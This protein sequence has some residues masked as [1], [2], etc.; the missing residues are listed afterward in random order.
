MCWVSILCN[1]YLMWSL[2]QFPFMMAIQSR[3]TDLATEWLQANLTGVKFEVCEE[4]ASLVPI[5]SQFKWSWN[6]SAI[7]TCQEVGNW[8]W[9][10]YSKWR[11][12]TQHI[13]EFLQVWPDPFPS[14]WRDLE[15][16]LLH[17][18]PHSVIGHGQL[19]IVISQPCLTVVLALVGLR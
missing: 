17:N 7:F 19:L 4:S 10:L 3:W 13:W 11:L 8:Q 1:N 14:F 9:F 16:R 5:R 6:E 12:L 2:G 15:T 18:S